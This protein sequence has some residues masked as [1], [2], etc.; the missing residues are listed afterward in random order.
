MMKKIRTNQYQCYECGV[1]VASFEFS[2]K[3][4]CTFG[5]QHNLK[6]A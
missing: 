4:L 1:E 5:C 2:A 6:I 3:K